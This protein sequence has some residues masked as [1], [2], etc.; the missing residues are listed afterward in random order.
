MKFEM[1]LG[2]ER[3]TI[4]NRKKELFACCMFPEEDNCQKK[5][6]LKE[7]ERRKRL[8][9]LNAKLTRTGEGEN[10]VAL[11]RISKKGRL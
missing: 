10:Q 8:V 2:F 5:V 6:F 9:R 3:K 7:E 11:E 1:Y 4:D